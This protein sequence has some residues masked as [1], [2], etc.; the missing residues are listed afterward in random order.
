[1][2]ISTIAFTRIAQCTMSRD[3]IAS[4]PEG[5]VLDLVASG[6]IANTHSVFR[7]T[8]GASSNGERAFTN[9]SCITVIL[10]REGWRRRVPGSGESKLSPKPQGGT[11]PHTGTSEYPGSAALTNC[12]IDSIII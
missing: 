1:M 5:Y 4:C 10:I 12:A 9:I 11:P 8:K 2:I 7:N 6:Y 3:G